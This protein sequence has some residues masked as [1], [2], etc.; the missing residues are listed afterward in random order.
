MKP[1]K[2]APGVFPKGRWHYLVVADGPKRRWIKLS[3]ISEGLPAAYTALAKVKAEAAGAHRMPALIAQWQREVMPRHAAKTQLDD[4]ARGKV[5]AEAFVEFTAADVDAPSC[6]DFLGQF[7]AKP[8]TFNAYRA[9]LRELLRFAEERGLRASGTNPISAIRTMRTPPRERY[10]TD[11]ELRRIK[12]GGLRGRDG[13][14]TRTGL[15][16]ACLV[17]MAYL[18]A[19]DVGVLI[20]LLEQR[21]PQRPDE[22]HVCP[23]GIFLRRDKTGKAIVITWTP[24]L[25]AVVRRLR[26]LK[27]E[28]LLRKRAAQRIV[29]PAMFTKQDGLPMTYGAVREAWDDALKR[30]KVPPT[31]FRDIRA[32]ALTDKEE[33]DGIV[34]AQAMGTH[35]TQAQTADYVRT[36]KARKTGATR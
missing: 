12:V 20:R 9:L 8:R 24:R 6:S 34:Q 27:S 21:D 28:R 2:V 25:E 22:P 36:K 17:E 35:S 16:M 1:V 15:M 14:P 7:S 23:E 18:T 19:A 4:V 32:K 31:M 13:R 30:A 29:T 26:V 11:S 33:R 3:L 5:I 10:I